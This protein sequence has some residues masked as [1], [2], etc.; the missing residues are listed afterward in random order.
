MDTQYFLDLM[1]QDKL[2]I[3]AL[4]IFILAIIAEVM[5]D[6][7]NYHRKDAMASFWMLL[8][9]GVIEFLPKLLAFIAFIAM[10]NLII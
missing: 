8:F 10:F 5:I 3:F 9:T 6:K 1:A 2:T 7:D 4:P